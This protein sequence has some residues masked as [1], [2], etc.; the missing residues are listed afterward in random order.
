MLRRIV[1]MLLALALVLSAA[2]ALA[3]ITPPGELPISTEPVTLTVW[4]GLPAGQPDYPDSDMTKWLEEKTG[5]HI[6]WVQV[7]SS[8]RSTLFNTSISSG[9]Y[10]D[11]YMIP[12]SGPTA[13]QYAEDG[14][15]LPLS[16][17]IDQ[18]GYYIKD[19]LERYPNVR[20]ETTAPDGNIY[21]FPYLNYAYTGAS[22]SNK[23]WV[24]GEWLDRYMQ[25]TGNPSPST[26]AELKEMLIFFRD[27]DMNGNGDPTDEIVMTGNYNYG[28][29]GGNPLYYILNAFAFVPTMSN[30]FFYRNDEGEVVTDMMS[31]ELREGLRFAN[32]LFNEGLMPEEIFVQDLN[33]M[34][35][36]TTT[37]RDNVIVGT[38][39]A[40]Y[41][42]RVLTMALEDDPNAV[43]ANDYIPLEPLKRAD[44]V[45]AYPTKPFESVAIRD[46]ITTSC[47]NPE[48]ALRWM[49]FFYSEEVQYYMLFGGEEG[50]D[51]DWVDAPSLSGEDKSIRIR[52]NK[53]TTYSGDWCGT[54]FRDRSLN[55]AGEASTNSNRNNWHALEVYA[56]GS[57]LTNIPF[58]NWCP[59]QDLATEYAEMNVLFKNYI[60]TSMIEF[61]IGR[62]DINSDADWNNYLSTLESMGIEAFMSLSTE[63]WKD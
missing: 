8:E 1:P 7:S 42:Q 38:V 37:T 14:V 19:A 24:Y 22:V 40:P 12:L 47:E 35:S 52:G 62:R 41:T 59:D 4:A 32:E 44:G 18:Y 53:V 26:P 2:S 55:M 25:E 46:F 60:D 58:I 39:G 5:V 57:R 10:P 31:D 11:I 28:L 3:E 49:D 13:M 54:Y 30:P 61:A 20:E 56:S 63:Y 33:T 34:R 45:A 51:W 50:V 48:V 29:E 16:D 17:L 36:L 43:T 23:L 9:D 27:N 6:N 21:G 15:L